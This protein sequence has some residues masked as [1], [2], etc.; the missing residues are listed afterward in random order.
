MRKLLLSLAVL[1]AIAAMPVC[2]APAV[3]PI[4]S[5]ISMLDQSTVQ[6][7]QFTYS[8]REFRRRQEIR[9]RQEYRRRLAARRGYRRA[10]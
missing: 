8:R 10:Y 3:Q 4:V 1:G 5:A 9:R 7:V 6:P 2:A